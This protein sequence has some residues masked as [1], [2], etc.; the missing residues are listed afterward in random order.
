MKNGA[1][2]PK[3]PFN[4][5]TLSDGISE[6]GDNHPTA[7]MVEAFEGLEKSVLEERKKGAKT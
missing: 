3:R 4:K 1:H 7:A 6:K 2:L 5:R